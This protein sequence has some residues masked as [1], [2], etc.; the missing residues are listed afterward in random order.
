M[1]GASF[2]ATLHAG[3]H[4]KA[5]LLIR[6]AGFGAPLGENLVQFRADNCSCSNV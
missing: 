5:C 4:D 1:S 3:R 2:V 6:G